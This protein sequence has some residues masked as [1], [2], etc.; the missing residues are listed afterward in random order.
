[1]NISLTYASSAE[2]EAKRSWAPTT[3][4]PV[5]LA[6]AGSPGAECSTSISGVL[7]DLGFDLSA[8]SR[9]AAI[10]AAEPG[11]AI[12]LDKLFHLGCGIVPITLEQIGAA[13]E[14]FAGLIDW[15]T[16]QRVRGHD[17]ALH[18]LNGNSDTY[19]LD[20]LRRIDM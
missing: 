4:A 9:P 7:I 10:A 17:N 8:S 12:D 6:G 16:R 13:N 1:M 3:N 14:N 11:Q 18:R 15:L 5:D 2:E 20:A 19:G